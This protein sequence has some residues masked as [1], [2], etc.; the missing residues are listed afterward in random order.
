M[1]LINRERSRLNV[2]LQRQRERSPEWDARKT[3]QAAAKKD[4]DMNRDTINAQAWARARQ[5]RGDITLE[6][7]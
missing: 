7:Y 5:D 3:S 4:C 6:L 2:S 1:H